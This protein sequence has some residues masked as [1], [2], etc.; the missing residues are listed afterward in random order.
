MADTGHVHIFDISL[1][2]RG[3][4]QKG[5]PSMPPSLPQRP[6]YSFKGHRA[7]G[8]A[9]DWSSLVAG[10]LATG[11][12]SGTIHIWSAS[13]TG[14]G[15]GLGDWKVDAVPHLGHT[16][17][18]E[19]IQWSPTEAT[20]FCTGSA[21]KTVK[22]WDTR[23]RN[24]PQISIDAHTEDV[25]VISWNRGVSY[26]LAS[27]SDDG[28]F[29]VWDLR[30]VGR[31]GVIDPLAH[32]RYHRD[33]ITSL[34]WAPHDESVLCVAGADDQ[35]TVWD[36][37]VEAEVDTAPQSGINPNEFPP[38]L[39]FIHQG[40]RE[41]KEVHFHPQIPGTIISTAEDGFNVFKPAINV[42]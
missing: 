19:D 14:S 33:A 7:E 42:G 1:P 38:Q 41:I 12:C 13:A 39:L 10:R 27:G 34:E 25:N 31:G 40:Q 37:S 35:V 11:D 2:F 36:L 4:Q 32:F 3:L 9:I 22:I 15:G 21:D 28:S 17:S 16:A 5:G 6:E 8:F 24:G 18:V 26:L 20:V 30:A 29:K 23:G